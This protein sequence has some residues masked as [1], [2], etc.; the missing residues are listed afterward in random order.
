MQVGINCVKELF[1]KKERGLGI[2]EALKQWFCS[3]LNRAG[4][5]ILSLLAA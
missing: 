5:K 3:I 4:M 2:D 1:R